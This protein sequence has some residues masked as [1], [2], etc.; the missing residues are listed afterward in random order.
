MKI[1]FLRL[2]TAL[3]LLNFIIIPRAAAQAP[4]PQD[5]RAAGLSDSFSIADEDI[6]VQREPALLEPYQI[7]YQL[8][9]N[10]FN[11]D[12]NQQ[13]ENDFLTLAEAALGRNLEIIPT[14]IMQ[15][16]TLT[17]RLFK[18]EAKQLLSLP[19]VL[20]V[21]PLKISKEIDLGSSNLT[22]EIQTSTTREAPL[23]VT[24]TVSQDLANPGDILTYTITI[25]ANHTGADLNYAI[26]DA[27]PPGVTYYPGSLYTTGS[28]TLAIYDD[29]TNTISW[30]DTVPNFYFCYQMS[31]KVTNPTYCKMPLFDGAYVDV[32]TRYGT[33]PN[34]SI[35]GDQIAFKLGILGLGTEYFGEVIQNVP[36][37]TDDGYV[38]MNEAENY[39]H[40]TNYIT[41]SPFP[42]LSEPNGLL[43]LWWR[44]MLIDYD[45]S[46][47]KGVTT[48]YL[49]DAWLVEFDDIEEF[50]Q[51]YT[52]DFEVFTWQT[53]DPEPGWPDIIFAFDNVV[54]E[55]FDDPLYNPVITGSTGIEDANGTMG[56]TYAYNNKVPQNGDIVC[57]DY[58]EVGRDPVVITFA[59]TVD[60]NQ[61]P[62]TVIT[63]TVAHTIDGVAQA[64][65]PA[66][67]LVN[68]T[69]I[70]YPQSLTTNEDTPIDIILVGTDTY[71]GGPLDFDVTNPPHGSLSGTVSSPTYTPDLHFFGT[72]YFYYTVSDGAA[73]SL[74]ALIL[75]NVFAVNDAPVLLDIPDQIINEGETFPTIN[76]DPFVSD[77]ETPDHLISWTY[78]GNTDLGVDLSN[79]II[80]ISIPHEDWYGAGTITFRATDNDTTDP[81]YAEETVT[82]TVN[83]VND[84]PIAVDDDFGTEI[85]ISLP[86][87][88]SGLLANDI[89]VDN[90]ID[91]V[92]TNINKL[93]GGSVTRAEGVITFTPITNYIGMAGFDYTVSDGF[94]TDV[95]RVNI[96]ITDE[97]N[98][99]PTT[100]ADAYTMNEYGLL[101]VDAPGVLGNDLD[102]E[103]NVLRTILVSPSSNGSLNLNIDGSFTYAPTPGYIG[104]DSFVYRVT[105]GILDGAD[106]TVTITVNEL[107]T[108]QQTLSL[109][110]GW[111]L[112]SFNLMP[113]PDT[114]VADILTSISG[115]YILVYAWDAD[116]GEWQLYDPTVP[117][118]ASDLQTLDQTRGFWINMTAPD[119][120]VISGKPVERAEIPLTPG[121]NLVGY[122]SI[123]TSALPGALTN[124][125]V[126][127]FKSV[128]AYDAGDAESPWMT[129]NPLAPIYFNSLQ[130]L[131]PGRGYWINLE[132]D[133]TWTVIYDLP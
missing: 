78:S 31:D 106:V 103:N 8:Q 97:N 66:S 28:D 91:L 9:P 53:P 41:N 10:T 55:W 87:N 119:D 70:A 79:R 81:L 39:I 18:S 88:D 125:G 75:I 17:L 93:L 124:N 56:Y 117:P 27:L 98:T 108:I 5:P 113:P 128:T 104:E 21:A 71:P 65:L 37:F 59:A 32:L 82:F 51:G 42:A 102:A 132:S 80:T 120:L 12:P 73:T 123:E 133:S 29:L 131:T 13:T 72:D 89:D 118:Y 61:I 14:D 109:Y 58:V 44:D 86:I 22:H 110:Q 83:P 4:A 26:T 16:D 25:P 111:N 20:R 107:P 54:G 112:V 90:A 33:P 15:Q 116:L 94:L 48:R 43:S 45:A 24:H 122:P 105:D 84:A 77:V 19:E 100:V 35:Y 57:F 121:W 63:N 47:N 92:I 7:W 38:L 129:F 49:T 114:P 99:A 62:G 130:A 68:D 3:L 127:A 34:P 74:E 1:K 52:M 95:G 76:L 101:S 115:N 6:I 23:P 11:P 85:N 40:P 2:L 64:P 126:A 36:F 67:F 30:S 46:L 96:M 69:P 50:W 60:L